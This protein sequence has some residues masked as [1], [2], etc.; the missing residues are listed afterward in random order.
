M[1][2]NRFPSIKIEF[3]SV[4]DYNIT[5]K[6]LALRYAKANKHKGLQADNCVIP[7]KNEHVQTKFY[8]TQLEY[9]LM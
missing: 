2:S 5:S 9:V 1:Q 6:Q 4:K 3:F 8:S 7:T